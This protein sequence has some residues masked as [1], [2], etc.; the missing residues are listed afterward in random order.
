MKRNHRIKLIIY[1][2]VLS[3]NLSLAM[4]QYTVGQTITQSTRDKVVQFC[5]NG[6]GSSSLGDLLVPA[7]GEPRR[8]VW[9]N[10]FA[11]H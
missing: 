11:S 10:F 3:L 5:A 4:G 2:L 7:Q 1:A 6:S 8:V 9:L